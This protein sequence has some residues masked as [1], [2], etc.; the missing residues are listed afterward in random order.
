MK[1]EQMSRSGLEFRS[2]FQHTTMQIADCR[3]SDQTG[4]KAS[5]FETNGALKEFNGA[6]YLRPK[7]PFTFLLCNLCWQIGSASIRRDIIEKAGFFD[8]NFNIGEDQD[9]L[10]RVALQ[11]PVALLKDKLMTAYKRIESRE[12][13][14]NR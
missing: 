5:Y 6:D 12:L 9:F 2:S 11:G 13:F 14:E 7:K 4:E 10:A 3:Y 8:V 1:A